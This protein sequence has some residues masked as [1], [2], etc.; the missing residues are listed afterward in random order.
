[1]I[2]QWKL[3]MQHKPVFGCLATFC[4]MHIRLNWK[5]MLHRL[6]SSITTYASQ[7]EFNFY[8][9]DVLVCALF[10]CSQEYNFLFTSSNVFILNLFI[11]MGAG[12][13][14]KYFFNRFTE[15]NILKRAFSSILMRFFKSRRKLYNRFTSKKYFYYFVLNRFISKKKFL[16]F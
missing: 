2:F 10:S 1:M 7:K 9:V 12:M 16:I 11:M 14:S 3:R 5:V 8:Y 13:C 15:L 6:W 4:I